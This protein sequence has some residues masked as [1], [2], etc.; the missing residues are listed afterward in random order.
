[1]RQVVHTGLSTVRELR[2]WIGRIE[3]SGYATASVGRRRTALYHLA[4]CSV[5]QVVAIRLVLVHHKYL[6]AFALGQEV[7]EV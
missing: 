2:V 6:E 4:G 5:A 7:A 1:M 3:V